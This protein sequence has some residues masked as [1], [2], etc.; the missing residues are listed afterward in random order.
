[1]HASLEAGDHAIVHWPCYQSLSQVAQS[2]GCK[3]TR[4]EAREENGWALDLDELR[5]L[6]QA[7]TRAVVVNVPHNPTGYLMPHETY[8]ELSV[9]AQGR[10]ALL[11]SDEVYRESEYDPKDR[12]PAGCDLGDHAVSLGVTSKTYGL[13]G[14]RIGWIATR[15]AEVCRRMAALKDY[16]TICSSAPSEF[17]AEVAL[18]HRERLVA[19]NLAIIRRNLGLLDVFFARHADRFTWHRPRAGAIAFPRLLGGQPAEGFCDELVRAA[20]VLLLPGTMYGHPGNHFRIGFGR[21]N[22]PQALER[23][24]NYFVGRPRT[25]DGRWSGSDSSFGARPWS[26]EKR[27]KSSE[28]DPGFT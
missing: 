15:N 27:S 5:A 13:A 23:L 18:R 28:L 12:L 16:T 4:W 19:R 26:R 21:E 8:R 20:S 7:N 10:G 17:L 9:L 3:V 24:E 1:M 25:N 11:F 6:W 14:L 22:L 2:I